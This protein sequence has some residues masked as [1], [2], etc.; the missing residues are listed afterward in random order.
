MGKMYFLYLGNEINKDI[1]SLLYFAKKKYTDKTIVFVMM[2]PADMLL[3]EIRKRVD[4]IV[5]FKEEII[6][7]KNDVVVLQNANFKKIK[8]DL[9]KGVME[10]NII[11]LFTPDAFYLTES[12]VFRN[13]NTSFFTFSP[14]QDTQPLFSLLHVGSSIKKQLCIRYINS[15][16]LTNPLFMPVHQCFSYQH[17]LLMNQCNTICSVIDT[18][19]REYKIDKDRVTVIFPECC[20]EY[21]SPL[22][23]KFKSQERRD[24]MLTAHLDIPGVHYYVKVTYEH[25]NGVLPFA[26]FVLVDVKNNASKLDSIL[27]QDRLELIKE[28]KQYIMQLQRYQRLVEEV[29]RDQPCLLDQQLH[30]ISNHY[31]TIITLL[32]MNIKAGNKG[33]GSELKRKV[34]ALAIFVK[35]YVVGYDPLKNLA[36]VAE[37]VMCLLGLDYDNTEVIKEFL[38]T[39]KSV[40]EVMEKNIGELSKMI[41]IYTD[42]ELAAT[43]GIPK[44]YFGYRRVCYADNYSFH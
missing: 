13:D 16:D 7:S 43:F 14:F 30:E 38:K 36:A 11:K 28:K 18:L 25:E 15:G 8:S 23:K 10:N 12:D 27:F 40:S 26:N 31:I 1:L 21:L 34:K 44:E 24:G 37:E 41:D 9:E 4:Q 39:Y 33:V 42:K 32:C 22:R 17:Y 19:S 29:L 35:Y 20:K 6:A 2:H 5:P 3:N